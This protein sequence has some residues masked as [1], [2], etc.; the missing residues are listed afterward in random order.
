MGLRYDGLYTVK[1]YTIT[2][3]QKQIHRFV[4]VRE[5]GQEQIRCEGRAK[6]PTGEEKREFERLRAKWV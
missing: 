3:L 5:E 2:D 4:L 1:G 6:R